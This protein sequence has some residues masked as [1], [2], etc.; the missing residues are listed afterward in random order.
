L[1][2]LV[3][4]NV[5]GILFSM[6]MISGKYSGFHIIIEKDNRGRS[7]HIVYREYIPVV[8]FNAAS[9]NER[10]LAAIDLVEKGLCT[11]KVA[12]KICGFHRNT[13]FK[14]LRTK[15]ILGIE[16]IIEDQRGLKQPY[17]YIGKVRSHIKKLLRKYP[18]W[19]DQ[20]IADQAAKDLQMEI[21]R[22]AVARIRTE[23][24]DK[25]S[26]KHR[27]DK[28]ELI[29][30]AAV[31][32]DVDRRNFDSRQMELNFKWDKEIAE[33]VEQ[34]LQDP[35]FESERKSDQRLIE[36][37]HQGHR[38]NFAGELMHHLFLQEIDFETSELIW[39]GWPKTIKALS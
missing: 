35:P 24:E 5:S 36:R 16:A 12:G 14:L 13:V 2:F 21:S 8:R 7:I 32:D 33:K 29:A 30:L 39:P 6:E 19:K 37:L 27:P 25:K 10:K 22:S 38:F 26:D 28:A 11:Q 4:K 9:I 31:A 34:C 3:F 20:D 1:V 18:Q 17:K 15:R 23:K